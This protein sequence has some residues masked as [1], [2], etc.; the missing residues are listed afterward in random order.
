MK[1][2]LLPFA[3][4]LMLTAVSCKK[5]PVSTVTPVAPAATYT[6]T[7]TVPP[8]VGPYSS[9]DYVFNMLSVKSKVVTIDA[10]TGGSFY[11]NSGTHYVFQPN[12][13]IN[14]SGAPVTGSIQVETAEYLKKGD[15]IFSGMLP[16]SN[17]QPLVSGGEIYVN[18]TQAGQKVFIKPGATFTA[19]IPKSGDTSSGMQ[20]FYGAPIP[21]N[22]SSN[23]VNW[24]QKITDTSGTYTYTTT[25]APIPIPTI[26]DTLQVISDS[27]RYINCDHFVSYPNLQ[28]FK[29]G[30]SV[31]GAT[32]VA[33]VKPYMYAV[34]DHQKVVYPCDYPVANVYSLYNILPDIPT[35][36]I[37]F[38]VINGNFYGGVLAVT[39]K[40]GNT[41]TVILKAVDP[42]T[43]KAQMNTLD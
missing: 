6:T 3:I 11:G 42:A 4:L 17:G 30:L 43:F 19:N 14:A 24:R 21:G 33:T 37:S 34:I 5:K 2:A 13:F 26:A 25:P 8:P 35:H 28:N 38:A 10:A 18:A 36:F 7:G 40:T 41:Y 31:E 23:K 22:S 16:V 29:V 32:M 9:I 1:K 39:P 12:S 15:M 27:C 20:L